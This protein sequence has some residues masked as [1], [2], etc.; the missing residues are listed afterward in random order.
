M[1]GLTYLAEAISEL[2]I[3]ALIGQIWLL[4]FLIYLNVVNSQEVNK[5]VFWVVVSLLL[6]YPNGESIPAVSKTP[7]QLQLLTPKR[8]PSHSSRLELPQL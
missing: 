6:S 1:L 5:W 3:T 8:S 4:P 2:T 7:Y